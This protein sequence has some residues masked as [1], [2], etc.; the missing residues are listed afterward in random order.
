MRSEVCAAVAAS[1]K[2]T[3][4]SSSVGASTPIVAAYLSSQ[5]DAVVVIDRDVR[6]AT[7]VASGSVSY[8]AKILTVSDSVAQGNAVDTSG[9][10]L[11]QRLADAGFDVVDRQVVEDGTAPVSAA[12][13]ALTEGFH[14][15][16]VTTG[17]T[18]FGPRDLTPEAT[19]K[20]VD[21]LAPGLA[22][23]MRSADPA[24]RLS[25]GVAG[26]RD[27]ALV[28]NT[29]GSPAGAVQFLEAVVDVFPHVLDLLAGNTSH[30]HRH[31]TPHSKAESA[32]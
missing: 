14:G 11:A 29:P 26:V 8:A 30:G 19:L 9:E 4:C 20:V 5:F 27:R 6:Q 2:S 28:L 25:R 16:V 10:A 17:G 15:I 13:R 31:G 22:E 21:R 23:A 3:G 12:L 7:S 18:G 24:G 1:S 32:P